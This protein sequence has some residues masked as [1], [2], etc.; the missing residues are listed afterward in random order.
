MVQAT[1]LNIQKQLDKWMPEKMKYRLTKEDVA[2]IAEQRSLK[3]RWKHIAAIYN[4][5]ADVLMARF[6]CWMWRGFK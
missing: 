3:V 6:H 1:I 2:Y 4:I 5:D